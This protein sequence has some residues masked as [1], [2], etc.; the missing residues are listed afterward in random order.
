MWKTQQGPDLRD[1]EAFFKR[2]SAIVN[3][4]ELTRA[5]KEQALDRWAS[6]VCKRLDLARDDEQVMRDKKLLQE[7]SQ[8]WSDVAAQFASIR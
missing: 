2:P 6:L 1:P 4:K 3:A 8:A 7:I 5:Q